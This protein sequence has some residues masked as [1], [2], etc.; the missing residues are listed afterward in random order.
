MFEL[1]ELSP[2]ARV[3]PEPDPVTGEYRVITQLWQPGR[4]G[5][6]SITP[7]ADASFR[8]WAARAWL[9]NAVVNPGGRLVYPSAFQP[10]EVST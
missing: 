3:Q 1:R 5:G 8:P 10:V 6:W 7:L 2:E 9:A 4:S